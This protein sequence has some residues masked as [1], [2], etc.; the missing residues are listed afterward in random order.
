MLGSYIP[1][2]EFLVTRSITVFGF[3]KLLFHT[4]RPLFFFLYTSYTGLMEYYCLLS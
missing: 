4:L 2:L 1:T 3:F